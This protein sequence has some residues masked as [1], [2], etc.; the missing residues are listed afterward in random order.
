MTDGHDDDNDD[1]YSSGWSQAQRRDTPRYG[2]GV[3]NRSFP[4]RRENSTRYPLTPPPT[5]P[6]RLLLRLLLPMGAVGER[7]PD[8]LSLAPRCTTFWGGGGRGLAAANIAVLPPYRCFSG[9]NDNY[10]VD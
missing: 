8:V 6:V 2:F 1:C 9:E 7:T 4:F 5:A 3:N 10:E